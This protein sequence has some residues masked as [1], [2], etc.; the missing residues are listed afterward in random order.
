MS[1]IKSAW[2]I[3]MEKTA[4]LE[5]TAEELQ[6]QVKE[7]CRFAGKA[8]AD[9]YLNDFDLRQLKVD[10]E[11][12]Q[13]EEKD[14]VIKATISG[15]IE[16]LELGDYEKLEKVA[17][18]IFHLSGNEKVKETKGRLY[19]IFDGFKSAEQKKRREIEES[20]RKLLNRRGISGEAVEIINPDGDEEW[21]RELEKT[22]RPFKEEFIRIKE[23]LLV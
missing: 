22:V 12:Y 10:L 8:L 3:A 15:L 6:K 21:I 2:E 4:K 1:R 19:I 20:G 5:V 7:K 9:R 11:K 13:N 23:E 17:E 18:G 16:A 14:L